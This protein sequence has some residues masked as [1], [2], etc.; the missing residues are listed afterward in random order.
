MEEIIILKVNFQ[1]IDSNKV[2]A[3]DRRVD[4]AYGNRVDIKKPLGNTSP[5]YKSRVQI[6]GTG[7]LQG[8]SPIMRPLTAVLWN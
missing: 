5:P 8:Y 1:K 6:Q 3:K 2:D 4:A 7:Y